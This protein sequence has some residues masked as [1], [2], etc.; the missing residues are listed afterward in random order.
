[1]F[2]GS[3]YTVF[4]AIYDEIFMLSLSLVFFSGFL[5]WLCEVEQAVWWDLPVCCWWSVREQEK[6][7][8]LFVSSRQPERKRN[9]TVLTE[10][11]QYPSKFHRV[12]CHNAF[13]KFVYIPLNDY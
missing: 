1:M 3:D 2:N 9:V 8:S 6:S 10:T 5:Q 12:A 13:M 7:H 4:T 11:K